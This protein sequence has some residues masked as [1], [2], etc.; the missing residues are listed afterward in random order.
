MSARRVAT[1]AHS[2][3]AKTAAA[4]LVSP[5]LFTVLSPS[6]SLDTYVVIYPGGRHPEFQRQAAGAI[7]PACQSENVRVWGSNS[8]KLSKPA[9]TVDSLTECWEY[10]IPVPGELQ[11][12]YVINLTCCG[13]R[14]ALATFWRKIGFLLTTAHLGI[15]SANTKKPGGHPHRALKILI[16]GDF[17][18]SVF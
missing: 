6:V 12:T 14:R 5:I 9:E 3:S 10:S 7:F 8:K 13:R 11:G 16:L 1:C 4:K 18:F 17:V 2:G 15:R